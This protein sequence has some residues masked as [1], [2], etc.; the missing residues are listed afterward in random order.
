MS[1]TSAASVSPPRCASTC[2]SGSCAS[3]TGT[4]SSSR[5]SQPMFAT[6]GKTCRSSTSRT[7]GTGGASMASSATSIERPST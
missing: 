2:R 6:S 7:P 5:T 4:R 3:G 1:P